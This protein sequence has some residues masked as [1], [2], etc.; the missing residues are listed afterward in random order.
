MRTYVPE[1][2][3]TLSE[4]QTTHVEIVVCTPIYFCCRCNIR[5][6]AATYFRTRSL[7][8]SAQHPRTPC[9]DLGN[10]SG[11]WCWGRNVSAYRYIHTLTLR[12]VALFL[13]GF[14]GGWFVTV[15][16]FRPGVA[17]RK[18]RVIGSRIGIWICGCFCEYHI[19][20]LYLLVG[21]SVWWLVRWWDSQ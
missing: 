18:N 12:Y 3:S 4:S 21:R 17:L 13:S 15:N 8:T 2:M 19:W 14:S 5:G 7:L 1:R 10:N 9:L 11:W 20:F 6:R 16:S